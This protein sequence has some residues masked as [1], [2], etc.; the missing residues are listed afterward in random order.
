MS[1]D[2]CRRMRGHRRGPM[3]RKDAKR[4][5]ELIWIRPKR[6]DRVTK[7]VILRG[8]GASSLK[9]FKNEPKRQN[10]R[11]AFGTGIG[12]CRGAAR[13]EKCPCGRNYEWYRIRQP[14]D[15]GGGLGILRGSPFRRMVRFEETSELVLTRVERPGPPQNAQVSHG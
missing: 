12:K 8:L 6:P 2:H 11:L 5:R 10:G 9:K 4:T 3:K 14:L 15:I 13:E 7:A 1:N